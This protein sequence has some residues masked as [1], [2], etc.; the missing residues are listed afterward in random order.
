MDFITDTLETLV[1]SYTYGI[2]LKKYIDIL[3]KN[4]LI[5]FIKYTY[6]FKLFNMFIIIPVS[7]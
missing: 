2:F 4:L 1:G 7:S 3:N 6:N 5:N